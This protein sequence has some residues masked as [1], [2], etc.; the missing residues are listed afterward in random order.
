MK[1]S[2]VLFDF[3]GTLFD[4]RESLVPVFQHAFAKVGLPFDEKETTHYMRIPLREIAR[5]NGIDGDRFLAFRE[6]I[7]ESI[8]SEE[9]RSLIKPF[10]GVFEEI[11]ALKAQNIKLGIVT[12]NA[13]GHVADILKRFDMDKLFDVVVGHDSYTRSK[14]DAEPINVA[15]QWL[16]AKRDE[17]VYIGDAMND[18]LAAKNAEVDAILI[19]RF[20]EY[21][22]GEYIKLSSLTGLTRLLLVER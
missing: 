4:T 6:G 16:R 11:F 15:I 17:V 14:P 10:E 21:E 9:S 5:I 1:Y 3:D 22:E 12:S 18:M 2:T 20:G 7:N 13:D 8:V 19:D